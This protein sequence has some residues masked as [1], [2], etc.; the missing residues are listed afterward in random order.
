MASRTAV[1]N[2][3]SFPTSRTVVI[4]DVTQALGVSSGSGALQVSWTTASGPIV[5]SRTYIT[6]DNGGTYGQSIDPVTAFGNDSFV[7]GLRSDSSFRSNVGFVNGGD[8]QLTVTATLLSDT[9][10]VLGMTQ[11]GLSPRSQVQYGVGA[12]FPAANN[13]RAGTLT[14]LAH[15]DGPANLFAYGSIVDNA[16][17][18]PVFFGGR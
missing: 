13:P 1:M 12:L 4:A 18:D 17:G 15:A 8:T 16:S 5:T 2:S 6:A 3:N 9:G 11:I 10:A 14:L 7:P